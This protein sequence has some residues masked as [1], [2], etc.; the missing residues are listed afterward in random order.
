MPVLRKI[1][2]LSVEHKLFISSVVVFLF[3]LSLGAFQINNLHTQREEA[4]NLF[5][6]QQED[7]KRNLDTTYQDQLKEIA[8]QQAKEHLETQKLA[9][10][11]DKDF[12]P[13]LPSC[14]KLENRVNI[15]I[16]NNGCDYNVKALGTTTMAVVFVA[17]SIDSFVISD[18]KAFSKNKGDNTSLYY[19][20]TFL[21]K[22]AARYGITGGQIALSFYGPFEFVGSV[23][24][25]AVDD[26]YDWL[27]IAEK[28]SQYYKVPEQNFDLVY[29]MGLKGGPGGGWAFPD[30]H[31]ALSTPNIGV[32]I[33]ETLHL[34]GASDKYFDGDCNSIGRAN[35]FDK[36]EKPQNLTDIMCS[37]NQNGIINE[38]TAREIGWTK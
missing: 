16:L 17:D 14:S 28:T 13:T 20:N 5:L 35:P 4:L 21:T 2:K 37:G 31:R 1:L 34:F 29:Y 8:D 33:H 18:L 27:T 23:N 12:N 30:S 6:K 3:L 38:I 32:F 25:F 10:K 7:K 22:E 19:I 11:I 26:P 24:T 36:S 15:I 9:E